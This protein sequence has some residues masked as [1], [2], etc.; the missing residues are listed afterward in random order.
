M[1]GREG[2]FTLIELLVVIAIIGLLASIVLISLNKAR[3]RARDSSRKAD[4]HQIRMALELYYDKYD[5]YP[6][7][8]FGFNNSGEGWATNRD[9]GTSCYAKDLED[10]IVEDESLM[11]IFPH[12]P[13]CGGCQGCGA[14]PSGYMYYHQLPTGTPAQTCSLY[15]ALENPESGVD[16]GVCD[17]HFPFGSYGMNYCIGD[18]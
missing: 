6:Y 13:K 2:G 8:G 14:N 4:L 7:T 5:Y 16:Y 10:V 1:K 15:A 18:Y 11:G 17:D 12:D 3:S 9:N